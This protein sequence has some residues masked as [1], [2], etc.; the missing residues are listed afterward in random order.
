MLGLKGPSV[1]E[2]KTNVHLKLEI[3]KVKS[4][5]SQLILLLKVYLQIEIF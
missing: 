2:L 3:F 5:G 1:M 4:K